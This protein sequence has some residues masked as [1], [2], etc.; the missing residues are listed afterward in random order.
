[1]LY[2]LNF[3]YTYSK[4]PFNSLFFFAPD[5]INLYTLL[6]ILQTAFLKAIYCRN[7]F[8]LVYRS[9]SFI[10]TKCPLLLC[11]NVD[12][13]VQTYP[14]HLFLLL[15]KNCVYIQFICHMSF[16]CIQCLLVYIVFNIYIIKFI[17]LILLLG[18]VPTTAI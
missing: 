2:L 15:C 12:Q 11:Y 9:M 10:F 17:H 6:C 16:D 5:G 8:M 3:L 13:M 14:F 7:I 1:M 4:T 18:F